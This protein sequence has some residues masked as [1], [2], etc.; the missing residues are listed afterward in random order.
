MM[1]QQEYD[2]HFYYHLDHLYRLVLVHETGELIDEQEEVVPVGVLA[3]LGWQRQ[4]VHGK[5]VVHG[6]AQ[7]NGYVE[8]QQQLMLPDKQ[9]EEEQE[10]F[11]IE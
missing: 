9:E 6:K 11:L 8:V 4:N 3:E 7:M 1:L 2:L 10:I 5:F